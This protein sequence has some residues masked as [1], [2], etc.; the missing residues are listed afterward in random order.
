MWFT[1]PIFISKYYKFSFKT[2]TLLR[3]NGKSS[4]MESNKISKTNIPSNHDFFFALETITNI[5]G[6]KRQLSKVGSTTFLQKWCYKWQPRNY[7]CLDVANLIIFISQNGEKPLKSHKSF[8]F[9]SPFSG[10]KEQRCKHLPR[11]KHY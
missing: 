9:F 8:M 1:N 6:I 10:K 2:K 3:R 4:P 5:I 11:T 7:L